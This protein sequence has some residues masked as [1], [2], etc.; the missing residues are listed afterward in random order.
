MLK[1]GTRLT[2]QVIRGIMHMDFIMLF[3]KV[4]P[5]LVLCIVASRNNM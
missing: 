3:F 2:E 4:F 1:V 5:W